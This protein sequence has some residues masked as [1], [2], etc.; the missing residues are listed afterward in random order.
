MA[1]VDELIGLIS[2]GLFIKEK[3]NDQDDFLNQ[4]SNKLLQSGFVSKDFLKE[5]TRREKEFP[6]GLQTITI[7]VSIPHC[8]S[9]FIIKNCIIVV[10]FD[11]PIKFK[12]MDDPDKNVDVELAFVLLIKDKEKHL[13]SLQQLSSLFQSSMLE[14]IKDKNSLGEVLELLKGGLKYA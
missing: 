6:T 9:E 10:V 4:I 7:G 11:H 3:Y 1:I 2:E 12:R 8:D 14:D 13:L 5:I